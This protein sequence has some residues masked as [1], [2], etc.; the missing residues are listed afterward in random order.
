VEYLED[1]YSSCVEDIMLSPG[2]I[3][4]AINERAKI[5]INQHVPMKQIW[6]ASPISGASHFMVREGEWVLTQNSSQKFID[7]LQEELGVLLN[8]SVQIPNVS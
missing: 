1:A 7:L 5:V 8:Q 4:I 3:E 2:I 6:Y